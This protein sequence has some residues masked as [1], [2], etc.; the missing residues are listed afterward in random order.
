MSDEPD[1]R[2]RAAAPGAAPGAAPSRATAPGAAAPG[3]AAPGGTRPEP[4]DPLALIAAWPAVAQA[5]ERARDACTRLRFHEGLRRRIPEAAAESR[6]RGAWASA[7]LDGARVPLDV[8]R[9]LVTGAAR[10]PQPS[11][12]TWDRVRGAVQATAETEQLLRYLS[13]A[14]AAAAQGLARLHLAAAQ[15][16]VSAEVLGRPRTAADR[17]DPEFAMLPASPSD[18]RERLAGISDLVRATSAPA[19]LVAAL[20]HAEIALVRPFT[21]GNAL[22]ARAAERAL[23]RARGLDPTGVGVPEFGHLEAGATAYTGALSAYATGTRAGLTAWIEHCA[24][25]VVAGA[26][27]GERIAD[28]VRAGRLS[29]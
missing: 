12:P 10:W 26:H 24:D 15:P 19:P 16:L 20:V 18:V 1:Q 22:V 2:A 6:V 17:P 27:E 23:L 8:V 25:A 9:D 7:R 29:D 21:G 5:C 4:D 14:S 3:A 11:D 28:A 13:G